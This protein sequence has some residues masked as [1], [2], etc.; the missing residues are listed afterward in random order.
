[1]GLTEGAPEIK[2]KWSIATLPKG[3]SGKGTAF[4]GG[5]IM[6]IFTNSKMKNEA[7]KF[8]K[9]LFEPETQVKLYDKA[10]VTQDAYLPPNM[11]T[12]DI[13]PMKDSF[14]KVLKMQAMD[15]KG[16]PPVLGWDIYAR[17]IDE[18]IQKIILAEKDP[19][20]TLLRTTE[21]INKEMSKY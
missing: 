12:W 21:L 7:W 20:E 11:N 10:W 8:I 14:K 1:M 13:L 17:F 9:F 4:L 2:D 5:R 15:A 3:P 18:A 6:G 19:R 16:P